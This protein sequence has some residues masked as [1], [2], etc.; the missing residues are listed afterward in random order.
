MSALPFVLAAMSLLSPGRDHAAL[1]GA[2]AARV[3]A[4][5]PL[6]VDDATKKHTVALLVAMAFRESS[7][8]N[9]AEGDRDKAGKPTS[10]CAFQ[11]HL[12]GG[13]RTREGW[14]GDEL[15]H[16]AAKCVAVAMRMVRASI[17]LCPE[18]PIAPYAGGPGACESKR[19]QR[20]SRDRVDLAARLEREVRP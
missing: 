19:V 1:G 18:H 11:I 16:D 2:I 10:F 17:A 7:L 3:D 8:R 20:V 13:A 14:D 12:P 5:A 9:S 6:F 15:V 4:E